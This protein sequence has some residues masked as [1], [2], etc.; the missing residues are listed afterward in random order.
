[1]LTII[2]TSLLMGFFCGVAVGG[3]MMLPERL[4]QKR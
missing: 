4:A 3:A 1:M 2:V